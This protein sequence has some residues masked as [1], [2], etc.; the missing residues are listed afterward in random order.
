MLYLS[1]LHIE[2]IMVQTI[3]CTCKSMTLMIRSQVLMGEKCMQQS[4]LE[5][6]SNKLLI[7]KC[8]LKQ[9][10]VTAAGAC[11]WVITEL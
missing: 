1:S 9:L 2:N 11:W 5:L 4:L 3:M 8:K 7:Y 10:N 6:S